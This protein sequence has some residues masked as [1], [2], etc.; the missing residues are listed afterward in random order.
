MKLSYFVHRVL[1]AVLFFIIMATLRKFT[2]AGYGWLYI[3]VPITV[4]YLYLRYL[5]YKC[6]ESSCDG[7]KRRIWDSK[8][9]S[10]GDRCDSCGHFDEEPTSML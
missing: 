6:N 5:P 4:L 7:A 2:P 3:V 9:K 1:F 10:W 8:L